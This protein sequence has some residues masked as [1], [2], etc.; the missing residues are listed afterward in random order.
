MNASTMVMIA[1][2]RAMTMPNCLPLSCVNNMLFCEVPMELCKS[3]E[4]FLMTAWGQERKSRS[5]R[6][7][8]GLPPKADLRSR[9]NE[10]TP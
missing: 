6:M 8:S 5:E 4:W 7:S 3:D 1:K 10:Y 2:M 9:I